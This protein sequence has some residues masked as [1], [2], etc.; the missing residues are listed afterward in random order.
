VY[1]WTIRWGSEDFAIMIPV[2]QREIHDKISEYLSGPPASLVD[3]ENWLW[4]FL[5]DLDD[6]DETVR[7]VA[8][9]IGSLISEYSYGDISEISL[10]RELANTILPFE[11]KPV[12]PK[13]ISGHDFHIVL[14][15]N[16]RSLA[17]TTMRSRRTACADLNPLEL[18]GWGTQGSNNNTPRIQPQSETEYL[19]PYR[20]FT[21]L[22]EQLL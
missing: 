19:Y 17:H 7:N 13:S 9:A 11:Q 16:R 22:R 1:G 2:H 14:D 10:R 20:V 4:S 6:Q 21:G 12:L 3:V 15:A 18:S 8:G 5:G